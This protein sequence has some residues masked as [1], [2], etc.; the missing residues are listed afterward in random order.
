MGNV[1]PRVLRGFRD[2]LPEVMIPRERM[3]AVIEAEQMRPSRVQ[4]PE[5]GAPGAG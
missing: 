2:Y 5:F 1:D 4:A 3:L